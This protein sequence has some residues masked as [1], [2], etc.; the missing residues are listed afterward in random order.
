MNICEWHTAERSFHCSDLSRSPTKIVNLSLIH[1]KILVKLIFNFFE[2]NIELI[3][4][5]IELVMHR[6]SIIQVRLY[7]CLQNI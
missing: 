6:T 4:T 5:C 7:I 3:L 1:E 2:T